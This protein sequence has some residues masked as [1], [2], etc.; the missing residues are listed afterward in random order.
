MLHPNQRALP[1]LRNLP[2]PPQVPEEPASL[3]PPAEIMLYSRR[4][5]GARV[6]RRL[7]AP[8]L[9]LL[10][11]WYLLLVMYVLGPSPTLWF[12]G[13]LFSLA[14]ASMLTSLATQMGF[15]GT[16][17]AWSFALVPLIA[18]AVSLL[19]ALAAPPLLGA[20]RPR[21]HLSEETF[22]R[23]AAN[24]LTL[25]LMAVPI[26]TVVLLPLVTALPL[27]QPWQTL[28]PGHLSMWCLAL[29]VLP[30]AWVLVRAT[31]AIHRLLGLE[32]METLRK[33]A[34]LG[35]DREVLEQR[36]AALWAQDR[37]HLPPT[38]G[39]PQDGAELSGR[40]ILTALL[41]MGRSALVWVLP[42]AALTGWTIFGL[43]DLIAL[44]TG[45]AAEDLTQLRTPVRLPQLL[46]ATP[47]LLLATA[48]GGL[49]PVAAIRLS[50]AQRAEV[51]DQRTVPQWERRARA[52]PWEARVCGLTGWLVAALQLG[53]WL[54]VGVLLPVTG[55]AS[56][57]T[58]AWVV[59]AVLLLVPLA[60][61]AAAFAMRRNLRDVLYGPAGAYMRRPAPYALVAP[62]IGTRADRAR[63]P[64]VRAALRQRRR[65]EG[66]EYDLE[67]FDLDA[68]DDRLWV[69]DDL[70]GATDTEI[71]EAD[72][73]AG[74]L[75][76]FGG[77]GSAFTGGGR[78]AGSLKGADGGASHTI[79]EQIGPPS[80]G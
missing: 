7:W 3:V 9:V 66:G 19:P 75:P 12:F 57:V 76:D 40:G 65:A 46:L 38:P 56:G 35:S 55:L 31:L 74:R 43:T 80:R 13:A 28:G 27:G 64:A 59:F 37:R 67:A 71:R 63:D 30:L 58:W 79:P 29:V 61:G 73:A 14:D 47:V 1:P 4:T 22:R 41:A 60:G 2:A 44:F 48:L 26:L 39:S 36:R 23:A 15:S 53:A 70:P 32:R 16:S 25:L 54:L 24:R 34:M 68:A 72:L 11:L 10:A 62:D 6:L 50:T 33:A 51:R 18:T 21:E 78:A 52:N 5:L 42:A 8:A 69:D 17:L 20:M 77:E 45:L 49:A